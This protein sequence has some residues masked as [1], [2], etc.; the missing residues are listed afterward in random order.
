MKSKY[1]WADLPRTVVHDK[2]SYFVTAKHERLQIDF[3][4]ALRA[5]NFRSWAGG[6]DGAAST[7]WLVKKLGDLYVHETLIAHIRRLLDNDFATT[8]LFE[9]PAQF[10][11]RMGKVE[12]HLNS[13]AFAAPRGGG[14]LALAKETLGRCQELV[15]RG[16][17][18][19]PK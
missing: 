18:R 5:E 8:H 17:E 13:K 2:A 15:N 10:T 16:G 11:E 9:T 12:R 3:A 7:K 1:D 4:E 19:L 14:L 6:E